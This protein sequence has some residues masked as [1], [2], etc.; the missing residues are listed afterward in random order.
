M[1]DVAGRDLTYG[2]L[3]P[4][5]VWRDGRPIDLGTPQQRSLLA[6][7]VLHRGD[8][9]STDRIVDAL[10]RDRTPPNALQTVRTYISRL[11]KVLGAAATLR[12]EAG[13]YRL[14]VAPGHVDVDRFEEL[15][16]VGRTALEAGDAPL[17]RALLV[18]ALS[19]FRGT[20]LAGLEYDDFARYE[21]E[22][23]EELRLVVV[24]DLTEA[25]LLE[26][27]HHELVPELRAAVEKHPLRERLWSQLMLALYRAGRQADALEAYRQVRDVLER[28]VGLEP[29]RE[30][31]DLERMILLQERTLDH[32]AVGRLHGV[33]RYVTSFVGRMDQI[34]ALRTMVQRERLV[35]IVGAAGS[36]KSR[37]AAEA[38]VHARDE[39]AEGVWW[40]DLSASGPAAVAT[41]FAD[42]LGMRRHPTRDTSDLVVSRLRG[43][44]VLLVVDNCEH[45][46]A[47]VADLLARIVA[48]AEPTRILATSREPVRVGGERILRLPPLTMPP[49]GPV[50]PDRLLEYEAPR[51]LVA[52]ASAVGTTVAL[53]ESSSRAIADV[54]RRLDGLPLAIELAAGRLSAVSL[55]EL[56][57]ALED[58]LDVLSAGVRDVPVR[59]QTLESAI[60]WSFA[61]LSADERML[62]ERLTVFP[63][64]FDATA[65]GAAAADTRLERAH[66]LTLLVQLVD[67]SL[68]AAE[69]GDP[70]RYRMLMTV[71]AFALDAA[72]RSGEYEA[73]AIRHRDYFADRADQLFWQLVGPD[74]GVALAW[75]RL[76]QANL[77]R[78]LRWSLE[79][80]DGEYALRLASALL[81]FWFRT[82]QLR[83]WR[84]HL[85]AA[86]QLAGPSSVWRGRGLTAYAWLCLST[87]DLEGADRHARAAVSAC[88]AGAQ[89][90]LG[91][92]L[93]ALARTQ[94][95]TGEV[96]AAEVSIGRAQEAFQGTR[97]VEGPPFFEQLLGEV[98]FRR[99]DLNSALAHLRRS[100]NLYRE[101]RGGLDAGW[102][103]VALADVALTAG[104]VDESA[105]A[106]T[107][108]VADFRARGDMRGVAAAFVRLGRAFSAQ[109]DVPHARELLLEAREL[110]LEWEY[111]VEFGEA[112]RILGALEPA[113]V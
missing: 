28:E 93:A 59:H 76:D 73:A 19:L 71:R 112:E 77:E 81:M 40:I 27:R 84:E 33:P 11:R 88:A 66:V 14:L 61:L 13:G 45:V 72:Q 98:A 56:A 89:D 47:V 30:L 67:R 55:S 70:T 38:A 23:L 20:A 110:A 78:A 12:T 82:G 104:H 65:A 9:L 58:H 79:R 2:L 57:Q 105:E 86:L 75:G 101:L 111:P 51:L 53:D 85:D 92:A 54:V 109:G 63:A 1:Q 10:W 42:S 74:L 29:G 3:G 21:S 49:G 96:D 6:L 4:M 31:K 5:A 18:E 37:L 39:F 108:A 48:E 80:E 50:G 43:A 97:F 60:S 91:L 24:E 25:R 35:T 107:D 64:S 7:L 22:R 106:A 16:L 17:A 68:V 41:A 102:T 94:I 34:D 90:V 87:G 44:R 8:V 83:E 95:G 26:G 69:F 15:A 32:G 52:R 99:G 36:G 62:L 100:R 46:A 113:A 103:L